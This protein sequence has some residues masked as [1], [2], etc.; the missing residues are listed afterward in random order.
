MSSS[1]RDFLAG[2]GAAAAAASVPGPSAHALAGDTLLYPPADLS[3]FDAPMH[4]G[5]MEIR[6]G[7]AALPGM[8]RT[9][10]RS[11]ISPRLAIQE[12]SCV[13]TFW[14]NILIRMR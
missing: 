11:R 7:Y 1:R 2:L 9:T 14:A 13:P 12:F 10:R 4:H 5:P 8:K 3:Y 6:I